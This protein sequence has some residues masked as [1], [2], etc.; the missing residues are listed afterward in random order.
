[1]LPGFSAGCLLCLLLTCSCSGPLA[2]HFQSLPMYPLNLHTWVSHRHF[3][4]NLG[5]FCRI[6]SLLLP[7]D[8]P[9]LPL[10]APICLLNFPSYKLPDHP[11]SSSTEKPGEK[12]GVLDA[13][14]PLTP[15]FAPFCLSYAPPSFFIL[16]ATPW[17]HWT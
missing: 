7:P 6:P 17:T 14:V 10:P 12:Q 15:P 3:L 13:S 8:T 4:G 5:S 16:L 11:P 1:M 9:A 2:S